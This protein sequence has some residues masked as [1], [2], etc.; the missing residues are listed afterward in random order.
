MNNRIFYKDGH[1]CKISRDL[2]ESYETFINRG[3]FIVSQKPTNKEQLDKLQV[4][5][6]IWINIKLSKSMYSEQIHK[7]I[8]T[9]EKNL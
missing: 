1:Y 5:S 9:L 2:G 7:D 8:L 6:R 3:N 4:M